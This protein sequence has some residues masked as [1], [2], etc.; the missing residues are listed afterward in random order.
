[1]TSEYIYEAG[2]DLIHC[3]MVNWFTL[4]SSDCL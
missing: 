2:V 1:M 3:H 4:W